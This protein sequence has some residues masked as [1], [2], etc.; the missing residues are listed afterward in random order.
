MKDYEQIHATHAVQSSALAAAQPPVRRAPTPAQAIETR[1]EEWRRQT[2]PSAVIRHSQL[3]RTGEA[4]R[5][6]ALDT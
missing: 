6:T 2:N 1:G 4:R 3:Q 5:L